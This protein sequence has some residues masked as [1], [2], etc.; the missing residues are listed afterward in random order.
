MRFFHA[1]IILALAVTGAVANQDSGNHAPPFPDP[2][3]DPHHPHPSGFL[4]PTGFYT[5]WGPAP[6]KVPE[7]PWKA[8]PAPTKVPDSP[9]EAPKPHHPRQNRRDAGPYYPIAERHEEPGK[10][11]DHTKGW[12]KPTGE[13]PRGPPLPTGA[14]P[15]GH[16]K[17]GFGWPFHWLD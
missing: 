17:G 16:P 5:K 12:A 2:R 8:G 4:P 9:W 14:P 3:F 7:S 15:K 11:H 13:H 10:D 6:T 1:P